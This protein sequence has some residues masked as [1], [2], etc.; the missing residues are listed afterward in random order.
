L[1]FHQRQSKFYV[2]YNGSNLIVLDELSY[3][4]KTI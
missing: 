4:N 2:I 3:I 1:I